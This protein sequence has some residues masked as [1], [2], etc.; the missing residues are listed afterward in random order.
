METLFILFFILPLL[1]L[2]LIFAII[3]KRSSPQKYSSHLTY[4]RILLNR[5]PCRL[6]QRL[7][8]F[9]AD[10]IDLKALQDAACLLMEYLLHTLH[11]SR[12]LPPLPTSQDGD[13]RLM[14]LARDIADD[15][16]YNES[17]LISAVTQWS[18]QPATP[19][20]ISALPACI[21][22]SQY[23]RLS[24]IFQAILSEARTRQAGL[25]F[26]RR[27]LKCRKPQQLLEKCTLS[28]AS[29]SALCNHLQ[30]V[31][32]L[33]HYAMV[34]DWLTDRQLH[35]DALRQTAMQRQVRLADELRT[36]IHCFSALERLN[37]SSIAADL[38]EVHG[39]LL[40]D[41]A[42]TYPRMTAASQAQLRLQIEEVSRKTKCKIGKVLQTTLEMSYAAPEDT[43]ERYVGFWLQ[44]NTGLTMLH[45]KL[46]T[47]HGWIYCLCLHQHQ[48]IGYV[49]L[50]LLG[51][52][53]GFSFLHSGHP[54]FMLPAFTVVA[55]YLI[56]K[57]LSSL[58]AAPALPAMTLPTGNHAL[59]TLVVVPVV[60]QD[61]HDAIRAVRHL[62]IICHAFSGRQADYLLLGDF[63]P[64]IT[65]VS[66]TDQSIVQAACEAIAALDNKHVMYIQRSR[67]WN[68][69]TYR[70]CSR[71]EK[72]G[73]IEDICRLISQ[74]ECE[75]LLTYSSV[76]LAQL[77]RQYDYV[78]ALPSDR[79][80]SPDMLECMLQTIAH[81][82]CQ[83][84]ATPD[85]P[86]GYSILLPNDSMYFDG[87]GLIRPDAY[88]EATDG[89]LP[90]G[91]NRDTLAGL[92]SGAAAVRNATLQNLPED[93]SWQK[94]YTS[95]FHAFK[96][97][98]WQC[99]WVKTPSGIVGNPLIYF[100]RF[101]LREQPRHALLPVCQCLLLIWA[102]LT[103]NWLLILLLLL[104]EV[105]KKIHRLADLILPACNLSLLPMRAVTCICAIWDAL[106]KKQPL[107][108]PWLSLEIWA[109]GIGATVAAALGI[110]FP[111]FFF[112]AGFFAI[113]FACFPLTHR[114]MDTPVLPEETM[115]EEQHD[116]LEKVAASTW[117]YFEKQLSDPD[118]SLP[119]ASIQFE[120]TLDDDESTTPEAISAL[121]LAC[122]CAK[123]LSFLSAANAADHLS[124]IVIDLEKLPLSDKL[125]CCRYHRYTCAIM[126]PSI[127][128]ASV[129]TLLTALM[130]TSQ[131][132]RTWLPDLPAEYIP[133][134]GRI[135][136]L[137]AAFDISRLYDSHVQR[138]YTRLDENGQPDGYI[139]RFADEGLLLSIAAY[140]R[141]YIP[142]S[143]FAHLQKTCITYKGLPILLSQHATASEQL[144][145]YLFVPMSF[146]GIDHFV[147]AMMIHHTHEG[148]YGQSE[149]SHWAFDAGLHYRKNIFGFREAALSS[150]VSAPIYSPYAAALA[151][152]VA[153]ESAGNAL[154]HFQR[155]G[156]LTPMGYC[157][158][159]DFTNGTALVGLHDTWHQGIVLA[160]IAH[161]L[162]DTSLQQFFCAI[163][164]VEACIP[165]LDAQRSSLCLPALP[166]LTDT[167][168]TSSAPFERDVPINTIPP[169]AH[170]IGT[171]S[172]RMLA[173][174]NGCFSI[175]D[176]NTPLTNVSARSLP[177][178]LC[179]SFSD[180]KQ[181]DRLGHFRE[182]GSVTFA[183]G[184]YRLE[185]TCGSYN[186]ELDCT[187][188]AIGKR[189]L[190]VLTIT[191]QSTQEKPF[192]LTSLLLPD[193]NR[194][195]QTFET[196]QLNPFSLSL[197]VRNTK[198]T[199][200]HTVSTSQPAAK[201]LAFT[202]TD[203]LTNGFPSSHL[204]H[205]FP[206]LLRADVTPCLAFQIHMVLGG[207]GQCRIWFTT[208]FL[209]LPSPQLF[210][211]N[212][213]QKLAALQHSALFQ[214][215]G[216]T[217]EQQIIASRLT[218][219]LFDNNH[220]LHLRLLEEDDLDLLSSL[221]PVIHYIRQQ[222]L[223]LQIRFLHP[224][225]LTGKITA[226]LQE[227]HA[228]D[229]V[230]LQEVSASVQTEGPLTLI[231]SVA[232]AD[233]LDK[234]YAR[235]IMPHHQPSPP[236][237]A[238]LP[239]KSLLHSGSYGGFDA[240]T[241]DYIVQLEP[242]QHLPSHWRN[243]H[244]SRHTTET[245][246]ET[247]IR[248]PFKEEL[249]LQQEDGTLLSPWT[250][251]L[252]RSIRFGAAYTAWDAWSDKLDLHVSAALIPGFR[253]GMRI[254]SIRNASNQTIK[255]KVSVLAAF[256]T[257]LD[258]APEMLMST[259]GNPFHP[260]IAGDDWLC[261]RT[262]EAAMRCWTTLPIL[263]PK[264]DPSGQTALLFR[265]IVIKPDTVEK[266]VWL[267]G[268]ARHID[269]IVHAMQVVRNHGTSAILRE[270]RSMWYRR[271]DCLT[272]STPED[273]L[274]L[275]V[276]RI[277]PLQALSAQAAAAVPALSYFAPNEAK[278]ALLRSARHAENRT[279]WALL[280][281]RT[282]AY[283][284]I[285]G[286]TSLVDVR[287]SHTGKTL[288]QSCTDALLML[289][290]DR[291]NLPLGEDQSKQC[292][293]YA[294]AA[295]ALSDLR[296]NEELQKLYIKLLNAAD[297]YLWRD[298]FYGD[299][300]DLRVHHLACC[301]YG[302]T[303]RTRQTIKLCWSK[304]YEQPHG[305]VRDHEA[306]SSSIHPG[307][308]GNGGMVTLDAACYLHAL[309][310]T[311]NFD[312]AFELLRAL[313][314]LHHTD[315]PHRQDIF[316][317]APFEL[318]G[319]M[320]A[321]PLEAGRGIPDSGAA[322]AVLYAI[323]IHDILG[324]R[325]EG[326][327]IRMKPCVPSD[328]QEYAITLREGASTW[329]IIAE[330]RIKTL[331][332]DGE[333]STGDNFDLADDG[334][335]H[336]IRIPLRS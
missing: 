210:E 54:V 276:N 92:L 330:R 74:G 290:L 17:S 57:S 42:G 130:T 156:A 16:K 254:L 253:C 84:H 313:N 6:L 161:I 239:K 213:I 146:Q 267:S 306:D 46:N 204:N 126:D 224:A 292:F 319:G 44:T 20:E 297:T 264:D 333:E 143:H 120:P 52:V 303:P 166:T 283:T 90:S 38:D 100:D 326:K 192:S 67:T 200:H 137:A 28:S 256:D 329:H 244:F 282:A 122:I 123:E 249:W 107:E 21:A 202:N 176:G 43:S 209:D 133:L 60:L 18:H 69:D 102:I 24:V 76:A 280:A 235:F 86:T 218:G 109:Q 59:R 79:L 259:T 243:K 160:A 169:E 172:F 91:E 222:G 7:L 302:A 140:A 284:R 152:P 5:K 278:Y 124:R 307:F 183:L 157:D 26:A 263:S 35:P 258:N 245:A 77:E 320:T 115:T 214:A 211:I 252:P 142:A 163:P 117:K 201:A 12:N 178:G 4:R 114:Y 225:V 150:A 11:R 171:P 138:F 301:A 232:L 153:P 261:F 164:S 96:L 141:G 127:H 305:L 151:L 293:F 250:D 94:N 139:S 327:T 33:E 58:T 217:S 197:H 266:V 310:Q 65:A 36:A 48:F 159:I 72:N 51:A 198:L 295:K 316:R 27:F 179:F 155:H 318:H 234:L 88:L 272:V 279:D 53:S 273:T 31:E 275:L 29:L 64:S 285:T 3:K 184:E 145:P 40:S 331:I 187:V 309:I 215:S 167:A 195:I 194:D 299:K 2:I 168:D 219:L 1:V 199:L 251:E 274:N 165:L 185:Q 325:R 241:F 238:L 173:S 281:L 10:S 75:A 61:Q 103:Q 236:V 55:G 78:L 22:I 255:I 47:R 101:K 175:W 269:D 45:R 19:A 321:S 85:G 108:R 191:N 110:A 93:H 188:D 206:D 82:V 89:L 97:L 220:S 304:L 247:G 227:Y 205:P 181:H 95:I 308:P 328:W 105:N 190:H 50:W 41:P 9:P 221:L 203:D 80:P 265:E 111:A 212:S 104:P 291:H 262:H 174:A 63:S 116:L 147:L 106:H 189:A 8:R 56:R 25:R 66:S 180:G 196:D 226:L 334:Q 270:V 286:D 149:C 311:A 208:S 277:L 229:Q 118:T 129:G 81:P 112:P 125:P 62:K 335:I 15:G 128:A 135:E 131:A 260:F 186:V 216:L 121:M 257:Q 315:N 300:L 242:G 49:L 246:D 193:L 37:W 324:F 177:Y 182:N 148:V 322:A 230:E 223:K 162:A 30:A 154:L 271:L 294:L 336:H 314:P 233:Q 134:S 83:R 99:P 207:R 240:E 332:I 23:Q 248:T 298:S 71:D 113:L 39:R 289:P 32:A 34:E 14:D 237:P 144:L 317:C 296:P 68:A 73:A 323:I 312:A 158:A 87:V 70:Y 119:S 98:R 170:L 13:C 268:Y 132:L 228:E 136:S 287:L 288:Y 231:G